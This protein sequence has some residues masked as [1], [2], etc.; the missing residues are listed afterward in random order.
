MSPFN[1]ESRTPV[2][3]EINGRQYVGHYR[4]VNGSVIAYLGDD[5]RLASCDINGPEAVARWL[6]SDMS[7]KKQKK[8]RASKSC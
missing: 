3:V 4:V 1:A 2:E 8:E 6:I 7:R 5:C